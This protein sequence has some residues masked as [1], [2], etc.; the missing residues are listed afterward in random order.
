MSTGQWWGE[1]EN[2]K[3]VLN[4]EAVRV[5]GLTDPVG[6]VVRIINSH[7]SSD[8]GIESMQAYEVAGVVK[9]FHTMS[10]HNA[11][12]PAIFRQNEFSDQ[13]FL[14]IVP[15]GE[16][17]VIRRLTA[18]L[19]DIHPSL[20][21]ASLTPLPEIYDRLHRSEN[22]GMKLF[23]LMAV[24]CLLISLTGVY[25][26]AVTSTMRRR[27]EIA[28]RK[29]VG[30]EVNDITR[31]FFREYTLQVI[32]AGAIGITIA[33]IAVMHWLR[34]YAYRTG[35][36]WWLLVGIMVEIVLV[37]LLTVLAQVLSAARSNPAEVVKSE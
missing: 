24:V 37:V 12:Y 6:T 18:V 19:P 11:L 30:A 36:P 26:V 28:V 5:M 2:K 1:G 22:V 3:I 20:T 8:T 33:C 29:I 14:R 15:G 7:D 10:L 13:I 35:I 4:E 23:S 17:E 16:E 31:I 9:D 21:D 34:S 32:L 25:A 27:K